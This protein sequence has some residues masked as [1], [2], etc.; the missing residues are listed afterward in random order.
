VRRPVRLLLGSDYAAQCDVLGHKGASATQPGL[1]CTSTRCPSKA[2]SLLD[3]AYC[4]LQVD[5]HL[6]EA[7]HFAV[8]MVAD[9]VAP[10]VG[11]PGTSAH[12]CSVVRSPLLAINPS[13][14]VPILL[15]TTQGVNHRYLRM[16]I[17]M[18][19][20]F[21]SASNGA[22]AGR[23]A[24]AA[25]AAELVEL[26]HERVRVRP[27]SYHGGLF[28]GH[29]CHTIGENIVDVCLAL[30]G[31]V[32]ETHLAAYERAWSLWNRVRKMLNC[33]AIIS[34]EEAAQLRADTSSMVSLLKGS[35]PWLSISPKLQILMCHAP[36]FLECFGSIGLYGEQ[37]LEAWHGRYGQNAVKYPG[38]TELE[39]AAAF[40]REM[41]LAREAGSDVLARY[42]PSRKLVKAGARK[43]TKPDDKRRRENK[44]RLP[45][46]L[47]ENGK[48]EKKRKQWA[49][50]ISGEAGTTVGAY[51]EREH[52]KRG[53]A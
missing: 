22:V 3:A 41:A 2:H 51:L 38:A 31:K 48:A 53:Q 27:T 40:M 25:F 4:T 32:S 34:A 8:R 50:G 29:D 44:P 42:A 14:I 30:K 47:A 23:H 37:G 1:G 7:T 16:G 12:D 10:T 11:A 39:R 5:R 17:D 21:R 19:M 26:L 15:H 33:A 20:V 6:R 13:Q 9:G 45:A 43:A 46:C 35:F 36:D 49:A 28:I 52:N 18:V 24:G